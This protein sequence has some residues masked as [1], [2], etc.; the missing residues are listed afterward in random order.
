MCSS[1]LFCFVCSGNGNICIRCT[2]EDA[3]EAETVN[4]EQSN[5]F[6][7]VLPSPKL[8]DSRCEVW[9]MILY[10]I[11]AECRNGVAILRGIRVSINIGW[12]ELKRAGV[13]WLVVAQ[14]LS[15]NFPLA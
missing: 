7:T 6:P 10:Q 15:N 11:A 13:M 1:D 14:L 3:A 9:S 5:P 4:G 2:A 8:P 12:P